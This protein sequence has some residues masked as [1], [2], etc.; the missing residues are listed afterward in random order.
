[1]QKIT[2]FLWYDGN[3]IEA[4]EYYLSIFKDGKM[5]QI[6]QM[7]PDGPVLLASFQLFGQEYIALNGGPMY[8]FSP[9]VSFSINCETQEEV[10]A[11]YDQLSAGGQQQPCGWLVDK[12]GLSWQVV[13]SVLP[14]LLHH[15][16]PSKV[17]RVS[18]ALMKMTKLDIQALTEA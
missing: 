14:K 6:T 17:K 8:Q 9:A 3:A 15:S 7:G 1:M 18:D 10:D 4:I 2:P 11:Y 5:G 16:D 13:P 12:F